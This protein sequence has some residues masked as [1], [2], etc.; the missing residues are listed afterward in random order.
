MK[1]H[2]LYIFPDFR[3]LFIGR[4]ISAIGDKFFQIA[5][6]WWALNESPSGKMNVGLI[7]AATFLP[8]VLFGPLMGTM[9][10][11]FDRKKTML[12]ADLARAFFVSVL[13]FLFYLKALNFPLALICVF[14]ISSF[15]PLF[16]SSAAGSLE[17]LTSSETLS[18]ATAV[19]SSSVQIS[20]VMG[21]AAGAIML[22][23]IGAKG[24]FL[25]NCIT[26]LVSFFFVL[27]IKSDL[28]P[29]E[30]AAYSYFSGLREGFYYLKGEREIL[31][32]VLFFS[33][34]NFFASPIFILIPMIIKYTLSLDVK[35]L[36][37]FETFFAL[38]LTAVSILLGFRRAKGDPIK[39]LSLSIFLAG[40]FFFPLGLVKNKYLSLISLT[41][42][43]AAMSL[44][45][46]VILSYFQNRVPDEFKGR[47]FSLITTVSF[48]VMPLSFMINGL[49]A[50]KLTVEKVIFFNSSAVV[51]LSIAPLLIRKFT[52]VKS[53][54]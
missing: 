6:I 38:G 20:S 43:G 27:S 9:A 23:A 39:L 12:T 52:Q 8:I 16:E 34:L 36:A 25:L 37:V 40:L 30:A 32:L 33:L 44:G 50:E 41:G 53:A 1:N 28:R 22:G 51:F 13:F 5:L 7:M 54:E 17:R 29:A 4:V 49:L 3:R 35:W 26:Y 10:D 11:R 47:F 48:A 18:Q 24:A 19:D 45:N 15:A 46:V 42:L 21:A 14:L 2:P 31:L